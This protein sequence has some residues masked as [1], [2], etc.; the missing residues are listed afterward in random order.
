MKKTKVYKLLVIVAI[1]LLGLAESSRAQYC[2]TGLYSSGCSASSPNLVGIDDFIIGSFSHIGSGCS[3]SGYGDFTGSQ[4][5][6][7][8]ERGTTISGS[9]KNIAAGSNCY[10]SIWIDLN[11]SGGFGGTG[12]IVY[13]SSVSNAGTISFSF[14]LSGTAALGNHRLR[15]R[16]TKNSTMGSSNS[17]TQYTYGEAHDYTCT[18]VNS[19]TTT[20]ASNSFCQGQSLNVTY[21]KNGTFNSGNTFTAQ[22]S[23]LA[24]DF[25]SAVAIGT[26]NSTNSGTISATI[27]INTPAGSGY[28]IRVVGD[29]PSTTG[30][31]N[32]SNIEIKAIPD[33][34]SSLTGSVCSGIVYNYVPA[35]SLPNTTISWTRAA[36]AGISNTAV[37]IPVIGSISETL[38]NTT[39]SPI[40][41]VYSFL[42]DANSCTKTV[43]HTVTVNPKP[44]LSWQNPLPD[45]CVNTSAF[46]LS[47]ASP[48][49][50]VYSGTGVTF[51]AGDYNFNAS[52]AG[53]GQHTITYTYTDPGTQCQ[54]SISRQI[55]VIAI[56]AVPTVSNIGNLSFCPNQ[57]HIVI[58][59]TPDLGNQYTY[60][61][62]K[63]NI[64]LSSGVSYIASQGG[65]YHARVSDNNTGCINESSTI[66]MIQFANP[67]AS[68]S[69]STPV[70]IGGNTLALNGSASGGNTNNQTNAYLYKWTGPNSLYSTSKDVF[71]VNGGSINPSHGGTYQ[72]T[73]TDFNG[74][75]DIKDV[76]V[77]VNTL[78]VLSTTPNLSVCIG[79]PIAIDASVTPG[80]GA[81]STY[82]WTGPNNFTAATEDVL[83]PTAISANQGTYSFNVLDVNGCAAANSVSTLVAVHANPVVTLAPVNNNNLI[84]A[85]SSRQLIAT[86][87][88]GSG[89]ISSYE[90]F[91]DGNSVTTTIIPT[92]NASV[93]GDWK[94]VV[95]NSNTCQTTS[96]IV[97]LIMDN[98]NPV[99]KA[100][101]ITVP[102]NS[103]GYVNV[104]ATDIDK[105]S[106]DNCG[107]I[108]LSLVQGNGGLITYDCSNIGPNNLEL[109]VTDGMGNYSTDGSVVTVI[110]NL[111]PI[112]NCKPAT[113]YLDNNGVANL[114]VADV[115]N[116]STDNCAITSK[117]VSPNSF[118][119]IGPKNVVLNLADA[120]NNTSSCNA[121]VTVADIIPPVAICKNITVNLGANGQATIVAADV[122]NGS[123]D[124]SGSV[125]LSINNNSF[126]CSDVASSPIQVTLTAMDGSNNSASC[127]ALVT[128]KDI[129]P[130]TV[131]TQ[132]VTVTLDQNGEAT[133]TTSMIDYNSSDACGIQSISLNK[134]LFTCADV[135][136]QN[137]VVL[138]V[139]DVNGNFNSAVAYVTVNPFLGPTTISYGNSP[140]CSS[141]YPQAVLL[142]GRT[143]GIFTA[144]T[145]LAI[146]ANGTIDFGAS[147]LNA[148]SNQF[149]V[150]YT[151]ADGNCPVTIA[152]ANVTITKLP[153]PQI[154]Y[155][156][157]PYCLNGGIANVTLSGN[158]SLGGIFSSNSLSVNSGNGDITL[159]SGPT[160]GPQT[161]NYDIA[162]A[163]GCPSVS[164]STAITIN[165]LPGVHQITIGGTLEFCQGSYVNLSTNAVF[166]QSY[167]WKKDGSNILVNGNG[168]LYKAETAGSYSLVTT[169]NTTN[170]SVETTPAI[171]VIV[172]E[173]PQITSI[174]AD[175]P[176]CIGGTSLN[177]QA[178]V[179]GGNGTFGYIKIWKKGAT[180][181]STANSPSLL[182]NS[183]IGN[184]PTIDPGLNGTYNLTVYDSKGCTA[185]ES[186]QLTVNQLPVL[187]VSNTGPYCVQE[188]IQLSSGINFIPS[189]ILWTG[190]AAYQNNTDPSPQ[191]LNATIQKDGTYTVSVTDGNGCSNSGNTTVVVNKLPTALLMGDN[192]FCQGQG[193]GVTLDAT[194]SLAGSGSI[195][196]FEWVRNNVNL[197]FGGGTKFVTIGGNYKVIVTNSNGCSKT[198]AVFTV[199]EYPNPIASITPA[200][201]VTSC[202]GTAVLLDAGSGNNLSYKWYK[203]NVL[204]NIT[205]STYIANVSGLYKVE[206]TNSISTCSSIS[207]ETQVIINVALSANVGINN[208]TTC[209]QNSPNGSLTITPIGGTSPFQYSIDGGQTFAGTNAF[210]N[211]GV[212]TYSVVVK[213]ALG[214]LTNT[215]SS[216]I[217]FVPAL[218]NSA[219]SASDP[220]Q[221]LNGNS[222]TY[223]LTNHDNSGNTSYKWNFGDG[224]SEVTSTASN[225]V[226]SYVTAGAYTVTVTATNTIN[227]C[228]S[229]SSI[230]VE[231]NPE[232]IANFTINDQT[233]CISQNTFNFTNTST[234]S[235]GSI[236]SNTWMFT[237]L[238]NSSNYDAL[239]IV[240]ATTGKKY[241][242]LVTNTNKGCYASKVD[243][244][245]VKV[246]PT[247]IASTT[248]PICAGQPVTLSVPQSGNGAGTFST[249][250]FNNFES[251]IGYE[252][253]STN[254][255]SFDNS[256]VLG[257][258]NNDNAS[259]NLSGLP[260]HDS[261]EV[262]LDLYIHDS[263]DGNNNTLGPDQ[264]KL[265]IDNATVVNTT[266]SNFTYE[267]QSFPQSVGSNNP[268]RTGAYNTSLP[269][270]CNQGG[271]I[272]SMYKIKIKVAHA[273][274][275]IQIDMEGLNLENICNESWSVDNVKIDLRSPNS[276]LPQGN[277]SWNPNIG[278]NSTI[279]VYP[280]QTTTYTAILN[281][282][283]NQCTDAFTVVVN[284][285][286]VV[287]FTSAG[288]CSNKV[289]FNNTST[290]SSGTMSYL[291]HFGDNTTSVETSPLK[292]YPTTG[293]TY[294][295]CLKATSD[296]GCSASEKKNITLDPAPHAGFDV[297]SLS[298]C[299]T[300]NSFSF[301]NTS[302]AGP[303]TWIAGY[304]W[305]FG[306]GTTSTNTFPNSVQYQAAGTY[307]V[308]L[309]AIGSNGCRDT[310]IKTVNVHGTPVVNFAALSPYCSKT[311][312]FTNS[313][314]VAN[315][316][317]SSYQWNFGDGNTSALDNPT[318]TYAVT[319][320]YNVE[321]VALSINGCSGS[322]IKT[323]SIS[324][325]PI[326]SFTYG[327][328]QGCS[329]NLVFT[330]TSNVGTGTPTYNWNFGDGTYST[331]ANPLKA[332]TVGGN[333][334]VTLTVTS[335]GGC[336]SVYSKAITAPQG[337]F[338]PTPTFSYQINS[339]NCGSTVNFTNTTGGNNTFLWQFGDNSTS[340]EISPSKV[341]SDKGT[342]NVQL[343]AF[344]SGCASSPATQNV[345]INTDQSGGLASFTVNSQTQCILQNSFRFT[346]TSQSFGSA[347]IPSY[348]WDFGNNTYSSNTH[349]NPVSYTSPGVYPVKLTATA[350]NGCVSY[351]T[352]N[353]IVS[354]T[355]CSGNITVIPG[356]GSGNDNAN[357]DF[358]GQLMNPTG[359]KNVISEKANFTL[360]PNPNTG[361]FKIKL[362]NME[363]QNDIIV[364][365][366]DI[367]GREIYKKIFAKHEL[368][369]DI[370]ISNLNISAGNYYLI[371][372]NNNLQVL[373]ASKFIVLE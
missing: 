331:M 212:G 274:T 339:G 125:T 4:P 18:I 145:G 38:V 244:V 69:H 101:N 334:T 285:Q 259:L 219:F 342:Y 103:S 314:T 16:L 151:V 51:V 351:Y 362:G 257:P 72:F 345:S 44:D 53:L 373:G 369:S 32:G 213:D 233:Q 194:S 79:N 5:V 165:G 246:S 106:S 13:Q 189:S 17:C 205:T 326:A 325:P 105:N 3:S 154:S 248:N 355:P 300:N 371:L 240:F 271:L 96:N 66:T 39:Q 295:V 365:V 269:T 43:N 354:A 155:T 247:I 196:S 187:N 256:M 171:N 173:L 297:N 327:P 333:Y 114:A 26:V 80:T 217:I 268:G 183:F 358:T 142:S 122:D 299:L 313:T 195:I 177:L 241:V 307:P 50:G 60:S 184:Y 167:Q 146:D 306:N 315:S 126:S 128:V 65:D 134:T 153:T 273:A 124:N 46:T 272:S 278:T 250:Y 48:A 37:I 88:A 119:T 197:G 148:N 330:N 192:K 120:S 253:S 55:T 57:G 186:Y 249:F 228:T 282:G 332:Y 312:N 182:N 214:C 91:R 292:A 1:L 156:G 201:P 267:S 357:K 22:L 264:W 265:K 304:Y 131:I 152:T 64:F 45:L 84:C 317:I 319:A 83:I 363:N 161:I 353:V 370:E 117:S 262:S 160:G 321:L 198:S 121:I 364:A 110:D 162:A 302:V 258:F 75:K 298:Q 301:T 71:V 2:T 340:A 288:Q 25:S 344:S 245:N 308:M 137:P 338:P 76:E 35:S 242:T 61:W 239:G 42:L 138:T 27:P 230:G 95:S 311:Y 49:G 341:Y 107:A 56:P 78:P 211:L 348:S 9:V 204:T 89:T 251:Y 329:S 59:S 67:T 347:W 286:P 118:T 116:N 335:Q 255:F 252:L 85:N 200:G 236:T 68:A 203:D 316:S 133:I 310:I 7:N 287:N 193:N 81:I 216:Q 82:S 199:T 36:V 209:I 275:T 222:F 150:T 14:P 276:N 208:V 149:T 40:N 180:Q 281:A 254:K 166:G 97:T 328:Q 92:Y 98:I 129:T 366:T 372:S 266:F 175:Q 63:D 337:V 74:C 115:D 178:S 349:P 294:E 350:S 309:V 113:I 100:K 243:S 352:M 185:N 191:I 127:V 226:K 141:N 159:V 135:G 47:G 279:T 361:S 139:F 33:M 277:L 223:T 31:D 41:V 346:N 220:S 202:Q 296:L 111:A 86:A 179:Q 323:I 108:T 229:S 157:T 305:D 172:N 210:G 261:V 70:C 109:K 343:I 15:I 130:P 215:V 293:G 303:P 283:Q 58:L 140:F 19:I 73:V 176:P 143:G 284:P 23:D 10:I 99:A 174:S 6:I 147:T 280:T 232:P 336:T 360:Y 136:Q 235:T 190:P 367:T 207:A 164:T 238:P 90:W 144:T 132:N 289:K 368:K 225:I 8:L 206:V 290:I 102:L 227:A 158:N 20:V 163:G 28:R 112:A 237:G 94:V 12:E 170:C 322:S 168:T 221:C 320:T 291:W 234:V 224:S 231:V 359:I 270:R 54:N 34:T 29:N 169:S 11:N 52:A 263:W 123:Y 30:T 218:P 181:F 62:Y 24:G 93:A 324:N 21:L 260:S 188:D 104:T 87:S 77:I 318:H 356:I